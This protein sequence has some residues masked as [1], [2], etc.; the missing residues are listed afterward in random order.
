[1][2]ANKNYQTIKTILFDLD[3]TIVG[4][5]QIYDQCYSAMQL[6]KELFNSARKQV[7][8][9]LPADH[10]AARNRLLYFKKYLELQGT[11]SATRVFEIMEEYEGHLIRF[12]AEELQLTQNQQVLATLAKKF[13]LGLVT[14]EN[15]RTQLLKLRAIDPHQT[16]FSFMITSEEIGIEKPHDGIIVH[17][18][19]K[20]SMDVSKVLMVGDSIENDLTPFQQKGCKVIGTRQFRDESLN[21]NNFYWINQLGNLLDLLF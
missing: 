7:K 14:N 10:V 13:R 18:L 19:Q 2:P 17:A 21:V 1:M 20:A 11:F 5:Q 3:D 16:Y 4:S 6:D 15:L 12:Y 8:A 9:L